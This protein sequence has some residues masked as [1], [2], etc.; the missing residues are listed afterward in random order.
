MNSRTTKAF[1]L[2]ITTLGIVGHALSGCWEAECDPGQ[3]E[4]GG[5]CFEAPASNEAGAAGTPSDTPDGAAGAGGGGG[6]QEPPLDTFGKTCSSDE[7][8]AGGNAPICGGPLAYC[9]QINCE[10]GEANEDVCPEGWMCLP[11]SANPQ[12]ISACIKN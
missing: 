1:T 6:S 10:E 8:C 3:I 9:I 12:G 7:D 5:V 2:A 11:K 4:R